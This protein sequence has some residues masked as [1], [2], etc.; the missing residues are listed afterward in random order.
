M[1]NPAAMLAAS[2]GAIKDKSSLQ[3]CKDNLSPF[4]LASPRRTAWC[5]P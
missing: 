1:R 5:A 4:R 3:C 2:G